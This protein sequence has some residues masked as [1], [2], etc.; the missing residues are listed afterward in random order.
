MFFIASILASASLEEE[1]D[2]DV[3]SCDKHIT[4][5]ANQHNGIV[6]DVLFVDVDDV[7]TAIS[8]ILPQM[9]VRTEC[10]FILIHVV[11]W[12]C[13]G[14]GEPAVDAFCK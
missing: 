12:L 3:V 14:I 9:L 11:H 10:L 7:L 5:V 6:R 13:S 1:A 8:T 4:K 2:H